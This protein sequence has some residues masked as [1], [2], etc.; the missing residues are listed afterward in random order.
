MHWNPMRLIALIVVLLA[1]QF[2]ARAGYEQ[3]CHIDGCRSADGRFVVTAEPI[4]KTTNHGP[5][6]WQFVW[7]D[8]KEN[9]TVRFDAKDVQGGQIHAH[10]FVAPDGETFALFNHTTLWTEGKSDM[11]GAQK[12]CGEP[13]KPKDRADPAF[14]RRVI[15]YKKDGTVVKAIGANDLLTPEEW[16]NTLAVFN[17]LGWLVEYPGLKFKE[18]PRHGYAFYQVSPD[19]TILELRLTP[20]RTSK[21]KSGRIIRVDLTTG[22]VLAADEKLTDKNKIPV[23]PYRGP[24][25]L[26]DNN[27]AVR[28]GY[29]PSLDPVRAEGKFT[30]APNPPP[31][32]DVVKDGFTKLDTPAWLPAD[33]CLVFTDLVQKKLFRLEAKNEVKAV[34]D[35]GGRGKVGP[36]GRFY[37]LVGDKLVSWKPGEE[38]KAIVEKA[39]GGKDLA[40]NDIAVS[41]T[42]FAYFTTL[43]DPDKGRLTIVD[44]AK[45]TVAVAYDGADLPDL[46]NPNGIAVSADGKTLLLGVSN[47]KDRK[48]S[49]IYRFPIKADGALDIAAGKDKKWGDVTAPDG[50]A[51]GPEGNLYV[52]AGASV[53]ILDATG[54]KVSEIKIPKGSGTNLTFGGDDGRTLFVTTDTT[55]YSCRLADAPKP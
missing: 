41:P 23:R 39:A 49:G 7:R 3:P 45:K 36:D 46:S 10:L 5:N 4:G 12:L 50:M 55:L 13:G 21:D 15:V 53:V 14:S 6:K 26:G 19:Y 34:R 18:T 42:G 44:V 20:T 16:D 52:T 51:F 38:P 35:D 40:L 2:P 25:A 17:R 32:L 47:Y 29:V 22:R 33:K 1:G 31:K 54:K 48:K 30:F 8:T 24:D 37:G 11:H 27:P 43:K 28:E 9:K